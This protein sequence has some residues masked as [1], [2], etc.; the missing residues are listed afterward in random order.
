MA[1]S[2]ERVLTPDEAAHVAA[3][4]AEAL[5]RFSVAWPAIIPLEDP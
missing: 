1:E 4:T 5:C 2:S 3:L